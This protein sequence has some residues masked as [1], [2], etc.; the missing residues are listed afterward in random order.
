MLQLN[1]RQSMLVAAI[2]SVLGLTGCSERSG[3]PVPTAVAPA[4]RHFYAFSPGFRCKT[5]SPM[6]VDIASWTDHL[7]VTAG[8]VLSWGSRCQDSGT[9]MPAKAAAD[10]RFAG[11][12]KSLMLAG[13]QYVQIA[14]PVAEA[15]RNAK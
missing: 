12:G 4:S 3:K 11:D 13:V 2:L 5:F 6:P 1:Y 8:E 7:E 9:P 15:E 14:D 10:I